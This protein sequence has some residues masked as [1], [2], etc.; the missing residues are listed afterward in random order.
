MRRI[1]V[2]QR[3]PFKLIT[4]TLGPKPYLR[5]NKLRPTLPKLRLTT[6]KSKPKLT[7]KPNE[8]ALKLNMLLFK[9]ER[10]KKK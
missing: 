4:H 8:I 7:L 9:L 1:Y 10:S 6:P 5:C 3:L 2:S